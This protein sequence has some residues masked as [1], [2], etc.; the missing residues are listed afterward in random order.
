MTAEA[1]TALLAR[2]VESPA[3]FPLALA[4]STLTALAGIALGG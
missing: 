4:A 1:R 2:I 3:L